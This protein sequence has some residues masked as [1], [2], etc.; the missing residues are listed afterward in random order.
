MPFY[1]CHVH[2]FTIDHVP[3]GFAGVPWLK[4]SAL[5]RWTKRHPRTLGTGLWLTRLLL[6]YRPFGIAWLIRAIGLDEDSLGR[7]VRFAE[8]TLNS[9]QSETYDRLR[10]YYPRDM[11]FVVLPM[12]MAAMGLGDPL[13]RYPCAA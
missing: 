13:L 2:L 6:K 1:N 4:L 7:I 10:V 12:D 8:I 3:D 11:R 5:R 9:S